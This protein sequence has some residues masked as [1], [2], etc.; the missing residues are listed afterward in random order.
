MLS[1]AIYV[2]HSLVRQVLCIESH[3]AYSCRMQICN[4]WLTD[5]WLTTLLT[6]KSPCCLSVKL[7]YSILSK[8]KTRN[9]LQPML[10][11]SIIKS[12]FRTISNFR[13]IAILILSR[14]GKKRKFGKTV[15]RVMTILTVDL[16]QM[17]V[18]PWLWLFT[19]PC[20]FI[21]V[22]CC[23]LLLYNEATA[24]ALIV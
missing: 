11:T 4:D 9:F 18:V 12:I 7:I 8:F 24:K 2:W 14:S 6:Y 19:F 16:S 1:E 23:L 5:D 21:L 10:S 22:G 13:K 17:S 15:Q 3:L 20:S